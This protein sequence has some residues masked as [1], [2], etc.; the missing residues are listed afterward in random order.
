MV[1]YKDFATSNVYRL[2]TSIPKPPLPP[3]EKYFVFNN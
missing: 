3:N 2:I 1:T